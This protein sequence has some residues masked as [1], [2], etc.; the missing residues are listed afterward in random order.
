MGPR[1]STPFPWLHIYHPTMKLTIIVCLGVAVIHPRRF[2]EIFIR[3]EGHDHRP[4]LLCI[5]VYVA[6]IIRSMHLLAN[7]SILHLQLLTFIF[8][9]GA[10]HP[11][12]MFYSQSLSDLK[13]VIIHFD[14][15]VSHSMGLRSSPTCI[16]LQ[17][18]DITRPKSF[19]FCLWGRD[20]PSHISID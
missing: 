17:I 2:I 4:C 15:C 8:F 11:P 14:G 16:R 1:T 10:D 3:Q 12:Q 9:L 19:I 13:A 7:H 5:S 18:I 6:E 20:H